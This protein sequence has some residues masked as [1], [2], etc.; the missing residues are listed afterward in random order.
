[1]VKLELNKFIIITLC[2]L[3]GQK[4]GI[5]IILVYVDNMLITDENLELIEETK[6]TFKQSFKMKNLGEL[7]YFLGI[8]FSISTQEITMHQRKYSL[9]PMAENSLQFIQMKNLLLRNMMK[10]SEKP[11]KIPWFIKLPIKDLFENH[12]T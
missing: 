4:K 2:F 8:E 3:R 1:M 11:K 7:R 9:E 10:V 6:S 12:S 5:T